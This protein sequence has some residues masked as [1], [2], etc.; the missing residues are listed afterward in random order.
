MSNANPPLEFNHPSY[1]VNE[2][3]CFA[4]EQSI[5]SSRSTEINTFL[6][7]ITN[8]ETLKTQYGALDLIDEFITMENQYFRTRG[9]IDFIPLLESL[10]SRTEAFAKT[11]TLSIEHKK[12]LAHLYTAILSKINGINSKVYKNTVFDLND[13]LRSVQRKIEKLHESIDDVNRNE[14]RND[15]NALLNEKVRSANIFIETQITPEIDYI[16]Q[17]IDDD[18]KKLID[19]S[20][21]KQSDANKAIS[22]KRR[23]RRKLQDKLR[24]QKILGPIK[25]IAAAANF[26]GPLGVATGAAIAGGN[27]VIDALVMGDSGGSGNDKI[28][29]LTCADFKTKMTKLTETLKQRPDLVKR[30]LTDLEKYLTESLIEDVSSAKVSSDEIQKLNYEIKSSKTEI[31]E[32]NNKLAE[33]IQKGNFNIPKDL[34]EQCKKIES[35]LE[36]STKEAKEK[37]ELKKVQSTENAKEFI[38]K[39][40]RIVLHVQN[41]VGLAEVSVELYNQIRSSEAKIEVVGVAIEG[42]QKD[43]AVLRDHE[44]KIHSALIPQ[45][46]AIQNNINEMSEN[47]AGN[48][49]VELDVKKWSIRSTLSEVRLLFSQM[50][51]EFSV[52]DS[53]ALS[54]EKLDEGM[55]TLIDVYDRIDSYSDNAKLTAYIENIVSHKSLDTA[56]GDTELSDAV[57]KLKVMIQSNIVLEE[58]ELATHAFKQHYFP[59]AN[60]LMTDYLNKLPPSLQMDNTNA[61]I[62]KSID[63]VERIMD[64]I[65]L[66]KAV[67]TKYG[68]TIHPKAVFDGG[69]GS[70]PPFYTWKYHEYKDQIKN[71]LQGKEV[72]IKADVTRGVNQNAV[73]F[74]KIGIYFKLLDAGLQ[75]ELDNI[76]LNFKINMTMVGTNYYRCSNR[77]YQIPLDRNVDITFKFNKDADRAPTDPNGNYNQIFENTPFLSPYVMWSITLTGELSKLQ[78]FVDQIVDLELIGSGQYLEHG[79]FSNEICNDQLDK[80][81]NFDKTISNVNT[82]MLSRGL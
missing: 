31:D 70:Q 45:I 69:D 32:L 38:E 71:L 81:Y 23:W 1:A 33:R 25:I 42:L 72:T 63:Q 59:I 50:T 82:L 78:T 74:K 55:A 3:K 40:L 49:H 37:L 5:G 44:E 18:I 10:L 7:K 62:Q 80:Y 67:Q 22:T 13:Y 46:G 58:Y 6:D 16:F 41:V 47:L 4:R 36:A 76:L 54:I 43:L 34:M 19:E 64:N 11:A 8:H 57:S 77:Y 39:Q 68:S 27:M 51:S 2:Y 24:L 14:V 35:K 26:F 65:A 28:I 21:D 53:L 30:K 73:T 66:S 60:F 56:I 29:P 15:F 79:E 75:S 12:A 9:Q 52:H 20:I 48:S 17:K 61:I